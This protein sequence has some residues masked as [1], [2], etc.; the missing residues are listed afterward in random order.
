MRDR[1]VTIACWLGLTASLLAVPVLPL[2]ELEGEQF[3]AVVFPPWINEDVRTTTL[4][5]ADVVLT[6]RPSALVL[7]GFVSSSWNSA[8]ELRQRGALL[9]LSSTALGLC[10]PSTEENRESIND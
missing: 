3:I 2:T 5:D 7:T 8:P 10:G 4:V 9:V 6:G 1:A